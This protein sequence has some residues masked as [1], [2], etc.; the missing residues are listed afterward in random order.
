MGLVGELSVDVVG[1]AVE[2]TYLVTNDRPEPTDLV[3]TSGQRFEIVV[4][5]VDTGDEVWRYSAG[6]MFTMALEHEH[7]EGGEG[8]AFSATYEGP[9]EGTYEALATL[10]ARAID[11][12]A[13]ATFSV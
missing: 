7:L 6:R 8:M 13:R 11:A 2:F 12:T 4:T 10:E 1:D 5:A 3:F 9:N